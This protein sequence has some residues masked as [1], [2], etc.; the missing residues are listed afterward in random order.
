M[1]DNSSMPTPI[2]RALR[3]APVAPVAPKQ[4]QPTQANRIE[5]QPVDAFE[6]GGRTPGMP[7]RPGIPSS[8]YPRQADID[9][10]VAIQDHA[11]RNYAITQGYADLSNALGSILGTK[12]ANWATFGVWASKQ[13]GVSIRHEDIPNVMV[14]LLQKSAGPARALSRFEE[15]LQKLGIP[16]LP[17]S[18][19]LS[20]GNEALV[21][22]QSGVAGGNRYVF[23]EIGREFS[24][25]VETFNGDAALDEAKLQKY[26]A[27]FKPEQAM[28][29]QAFNAYAHAAFETDPNKKSELILLGNL[30]IGYHEQTNLTSY[31]E[32]AMNAPVKEAFRDVLIEHVT[33]SLDR[34]PFGSGRF[35]RFALERSGL[36]EKMVEPL[37]DALSS[38]FRRVATEHMMKLAMPTETL[39]LGDDLPSRGGFPEALRTIENPDVLAVLA[40]LDKTPN[41]L[42]GT[43]ASDWVSL[44]QRMHFIGDLFRSRQQEP[45]LWDSP[46]GKTVTYGQPRVA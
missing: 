30:Q 19:L 18:A 13:A 34:M 15:V 22:V 4:V 7:T 40:K 5:R 32:N 3:P 6:G 45:S 20:A 11:T 26:L 37:A 14:D 28:L 21:S 31:I 41:S 46:F 24:R 38:G 27:Q 16:T 2:N 42:E 36:L 12:D 8:S 23:N 43:G 33:R 44:E 35:A 25:F 9:G 39:T 1:C 17:V 29:R 10:I